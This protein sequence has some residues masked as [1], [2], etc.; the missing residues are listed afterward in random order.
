MGRLPRAIVQLMWLIFEGR[1]KEASWLS[2]YPIDEGRTIVGRKVEEGLS[3]NAPELSRHHAVFIRQGKKLLVQDLDSLLGT[4]V[5]GKKVEEAPLSPGDI[6]T[7]GPI[8]I[9]FEVKLPEPA[10]PLSAP[11]SKLDSAN[12]KLLEPFRLLL[13]GMM[14]AGEPRILLERLLQGV[15]DV[16]GAERGY[17]LIAEKQSGSLVP[18]ASHHIDDIDAFVQVSDT[19]C[20]DAMER[21]EM[22]I[23]FDSTSDS[24][25][26]E[27]SSLFDSSPRSILCAPLIAGKSSYGAIYVDFCLQEAKGLRSHL[28]LFETAARFASHLLS[29]A[30]QRKA[31]LVASRRAAAL[32]ALSWSGEI[33]VMG[34]GPTATKLKEEIRAAAAQDVSVLLTGATGTGKEMVARAIHRSSSRRNGPFVPIN[35]AALPEELLEAELF[36]AEKGAF[37]GAS[38]KRMGRFELAS[39]GTLFLDEVGEIPLTV[40]VKLLRVLQERSI[41]RLGGTKPV[42]LDFRLIAATNVDIEE[43]VR[44][45]TFRQDLYYRINVFRLHL[46]DLS[47]RS[48]DI[49][50]LAEHFL[51]HFCRQF[52]KAELVLTDE[53]RQHLLSHSW[54][55]NVRELRNAIE[56][57][58]VVSGEQTLRVE[59]FPLGDL[60]TSTSRDH[61]ES[62]ELPTNFD[63][64]KH[65]FEHQFFTT[66]L[67]RFDGNAQEL[68][69]KCGISK[70]TLYRHLAKHNL[71]ER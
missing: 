6:I 53:A 68:G 61:G 49:I 13:E 56:R 25:Y 65:Q 4:K 26:A 8:V 3:F 24:R 15:V 21:K 33:L 10:K 32:N 1:E 57:A 36:G 39:G 31:L 64:A 60:P 67:K 50:P 54:P 51:S 19:V 20:H 70:S 2:A 42:L 47:S 17:V 71:L 45:S 38:E 48:D 14:G 29:A 7:L 46:K 34:E 41:L 35:C 28:N 18:V 40:Q 52:G 44:Q 5:N 58:V 27:A 11:G 30:Q 66:M 69:R 22:V 37:T 23:V 59:D 63:E 62:A 16:L 12:G 55:G 9:R 43:A